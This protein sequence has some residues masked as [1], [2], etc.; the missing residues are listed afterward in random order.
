MPEESTS[1]WVYAGL[2]G[3]LALVIWAFVPIRGK[4]KRPAI[5]PANLHPHIIA[6]ASVRTNAEGLDAYYRARRIGGRPPAPYVVLEPAA[7]FGIRENEEKYRTAYE[8]MMRGIDVILDMYP[9]STVFRG[10]GP[11]SQWGAA[12][13][14]ALGGES[15]SV[16]RYSTEILRGRLDDLTTIS[17]FQLNVPFRADYRYE[18]SVHP[19]DLNDAYDTVQKMGIRLSMRHHAT[20]QQAVDEAAGTDRSDLPFRR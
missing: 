18:I 13:R 11:R 12:G 17:E 2:I 10:D 8:L 14:V 20:Q 3:V 16:I 6:A 9:P 4:R 19:D 5:N 15:D 1:V 7:P